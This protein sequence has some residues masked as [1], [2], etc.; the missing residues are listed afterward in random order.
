M[1]AGNPALHIDEVDSI[2]R[3]IKGRGG[4]LLREKIVFRASRKIIVVADAS[5]NVDR[6]GEKHPVPVEVDPRW[7]RRVYGD[8]ATIPH[9]SELTL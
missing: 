3:L 8:I 1:S 9:V 7:V 6:L 4:A 2:G 5:K